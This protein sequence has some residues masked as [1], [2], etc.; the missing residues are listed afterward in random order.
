MDEVDLGITA[1]GPSFVQTDCTH[2]LSDVDA[3]RQNELLTADPAAGALR[4]PTLPRASSSRFVNHS[5]ET[6]GPSD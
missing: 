2:E 5:A 1:A 3:G 6:Q 4:P